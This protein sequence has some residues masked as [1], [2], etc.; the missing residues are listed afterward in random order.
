MANSDEPH[1]SNA[2]RVRLFWRGEE[3]QA[4][5]EYGAVMAVITIAWLFALALLVLRGSP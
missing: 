1:V 3:G 4:M 5:A 2:E